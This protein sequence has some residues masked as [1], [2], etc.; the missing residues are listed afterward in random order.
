MH[1]KG[2]GGGCMGQGFAEGKIRQCVQDASCGQ[3]HA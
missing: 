2:G 1:F 3:L